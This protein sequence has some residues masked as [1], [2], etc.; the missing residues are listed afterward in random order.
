MVGILFVNFNRIGTA[1]NKERCECHDCTQSRRHPMEKSFD[2]FLQPG[3]IVRVL[4]KKDN[5]YRAYE[6]LK[7]GGSDIFG[8]EDF[9]LLR[10]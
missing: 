5:I 8:F 3:S 1:M 7:D 9:E 4:I 2:R 6:Q 10:Q